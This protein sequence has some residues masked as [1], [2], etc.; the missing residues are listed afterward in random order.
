MEIIFVVFGVAIMTGIMLITAYIINGFVLT[1]LWAWFIVPFGLPELGLAQAIGIAM[2]IGF[3]TNQHIPDN[4]DEKAWKP[5]ITL[6]V[7]PFLTLFAGYIV[8]L[9]M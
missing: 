4:K 3:L 7:G 9:F 2:V 5:F 8:T 6:Y 1:K